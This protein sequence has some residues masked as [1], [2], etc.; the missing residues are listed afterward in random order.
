MVNNVVGWGDPVQGVCRVLG[1]WIGLLGSQ[2]TWRRCC[3]IQFKGDVGV[4]GEMGA[5]VWRVVY[6]CAGFIV[7][8][9]I[10]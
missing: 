8:L 6:D 4:L 10:R 3:D 7:V 2:I 5:V 9:A 1:S